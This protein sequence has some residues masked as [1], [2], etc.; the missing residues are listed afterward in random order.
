MANGLNKV[1]LL[2]NLGA[3][4][5]LKMTSSGQAVMKLRMATSRTYLDRNKVKQESTQWHTVI[6]WGKRAEAL[7]KFLTKGSRLHIEGE[8]QYREWDKDDGTKGYVTEVRAFEV[9]LC[10]KAPS[11]RPPMPDDDDASDYGRGGGDDDI[12]F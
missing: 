7:A 3:D 1:F 12:P 10:E 9:T 5:E 6:I 2:G 4:P 8:L 11:N